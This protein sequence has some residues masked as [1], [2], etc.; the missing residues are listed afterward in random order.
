MPVTC[1]LPRSLVA[2]PGVYQA[3]SAGSV[4]G[5]GRQLQGPWR[6]LSQERGQGQDMPPSWA[7]VR[8]AWDP[9]ISDAGQATRW[10]LGAQAQL[11][12]SRAGLQGPPWGGPGP[13]P[14]HSPALMATRP[15]PLHSAFLGPGFGQQ[16]R[17]AVTHPH[18]HCPPIHTRNSP[19]PCMC[20]MT[21]RLRNFSSGPSILNSLDSSIPQQSRA[22][23]LKSALKFK[24]N[25]C[26]DSA[27]YLTSLSLSFSSINWES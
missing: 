18:L 5:W 7:A 12:A 26:C 24:C 17:S 11:I 15:C 6:R 8:G 1:W 20:Y 19:T 25:W 23:A 22:S 10:D 4:P 9:G 14:A 27:H 21:Q 16:L 13:L 3:L 2:A